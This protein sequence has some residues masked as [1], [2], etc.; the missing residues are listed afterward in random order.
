MGYYKEL[1]TDLSY[2]ANRSERGKTRLEWWDVERKE[3]A[4]S[5]LIIVMHKKGFGNRPDEMHAVPSFQGLSLLR[6]YRIKTKWEKLRSLAKVARMIQ[7]IQIQKE[8]H[9]P[10]CLVNATRLWNAIDGLDPFSNQ[11]ELLWG[12]MLD[13]IP[14]AFRNPNEINSMR[15]TYRKPN[16]G[17]RM[18]QEGEA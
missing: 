4:K 15:F 17:L 7:R 6:H 18:F 16:G 9:D 1:I 14:W 5:G 3:L 10:V 11:C 13:V 12:V 8:R 2:I